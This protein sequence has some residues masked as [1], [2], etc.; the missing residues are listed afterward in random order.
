MTF[1]NAVK[2]T[3]EFTRTTN[4]MKTLKS[5]TNALVDFF[6]QAAAA[7]TWDT[8]Q[9]ENIFAKAL[10][11]DQ[12]LA[13]RLVFWLRDVR[14]GAGERRAFRTCMN[15]L[16]RVHPHILVKLLPLV[17][18]Y[19]RY[20]DL[21]IFT[22]SVVKNAAFTILAHALTITEDP[23]VAKWLPRE[24]GSKRA[25]ARE[26][27][28]FLGW[29]PRQYRKV[30]S[31]MTKV[32]ESLMCAG[33]WDQIEYDKLPSVASARYQKSF[34][35]HDESGHYAAFKES[36]VKG[37]VT[38]NA[39]SLF[40]YDVI[41]SLKKGDAVVA[42]AQWQALENFIPEG[43][44]VL[45]LVDTS[46]SMTWAKVAGDLTALDV[47]VSLGLYVATKN[48]GPF[49]GAWLNFNSNS[50]LKMIKGNN[51]VDQYNGLV[52]DNDWGGSTNL[53]SAFDSILNV[54]IKNHVAPEDMP[55][56]LVI[57]SDMQFDSC[58]N[59]TAMDMIDIKYAQAGYDRPAIVFWNLAAQANQSPVKFDKSGA[60]L[61]SGFSPAI[62]KAILSGD[63]SQLNPLMVMM[64]AITNP[65]YD[66][67]SQALL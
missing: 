24:K 7:R 59:F 21:L 40:P 49:E 45:P 2:A 61:V 51:I 52:S 31:R 39:S 9:I 50:H 20:D 62:F 38:I 34:G 53:N 12:E 13:F 58:V 33:Q 60:A 10:S 26:F 32:V 37:E 1:M 16:E 27:I 3:P 44:Y 8:K 64:Q 54:A 48:K 11:E 25:L 30:L 42:N 15:Y 57:L 36:L 18:Q 23:L 14:G 29:T 63:Q 43:T 56:I 5:S 67:V 46:G 65:R 66:A 4:G 41:R 6:F 55:Q 19:G 47:A 35:N 28:A 22:D 17:P